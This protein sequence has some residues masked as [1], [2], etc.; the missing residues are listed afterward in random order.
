MTSTI[1]VKFLKPLAEE[2]VAKG[3]RVFENTRVDD[4]ESNKRPVAVTREGRRVE[5]DYLVVCSHY[6][7]YDNEG[8][9]YARLSPNRSYSIAAETDKE[10]PGGMYVNA[11]QP[12][13][14]L[15]SI[16]LEGKE[17]V[18]QGAM[19]IMWDTNRIQKKAIISC[20]SL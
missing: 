13:H 5:G 2:I 20:I 9:Y 19:V 16:Q 17:L 8:F 6:P 18:W 10:H 12:A 4:I 7:F 3:G 14:S 11:G 15:R 1:W